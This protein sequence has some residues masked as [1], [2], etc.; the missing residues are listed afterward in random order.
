LTEEPQ[1]EYYDSSKDAEA[2][3]ARR[4]ELKQQRQAFRRGNIKKLLGHPLAVIGMLVILIITLMALI[5]PILIKTVWKPAIYD[6]IHGFDPDMEHHPSLPSHNHLLGTD[7]LGRDVLSQL[8]FAARTSLGVGLLAGLVAIL[9]ALVIG[10]VS[11]YYGGWVDNTLMS[12]ADIFLLMPPAI[13]T[14]IVGLVLPM[15][16][17]TMGLLFGIL[18]GLGSLAIT[19]KSQALTIR[20]KPYVDSSRLSGASGWHIMVKHILPGM[21]SVMMVSMM[22]VVS[23]AMMIEALISFYQGS[24]VR[25]SWG[26]MIW[27]IQSTFYLSQY[28]AQWNAVLPPALAITL[29]CASFYMVGRALD[30]I[31]NPRLRER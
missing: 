7:A 10:V 18:A 8:M 6:P 20:I 13:I 14:L 11:A 1:Y 29:L 4:E 23:Q 15:T 3:K 26:T 22:F 28:A 9:I 12:L 27:F 21:L 16:W 19:F 31:L 17:V 25:L 2:R 5:Q 30:E 24:A